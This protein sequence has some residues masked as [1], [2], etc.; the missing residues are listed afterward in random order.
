MREEQRPKLFS[1]RTRKGHR[2]ATVHSAPP[3]RSREPNS[4]T[5]AGS[6]L[7][8]REAF[9]DLHEIRSRLE[10]ANDR[11]VEL[12]ELAPVGFL[13]LD[14]HGC[15]REI[16]KRAAQM[17]AFPV[18]WLI[19]KPF[20]VFVARH[21][22]KRFLSYMISLRKTQPK[23]IQ[24]D[25]FVDE[26]LLPVQLIGQTTRTGHAMIHKMTL[27]DLTDRKGNE[28]RLE[29]L[30]S[31]WHSLI[32]N[33][34]DVV[35]TLGQS[36]KILFVNRPVWGY[37]VR[38]LVGTH[39]IDF[40]PEEERPAFQK[41]LDSVFKTGKRASCDVAGIDGDKNSWF[42]FSFGPMDG[43]RDGEAGGTTLLIREISEHKHVE[44]KLRSSG[45]TMRQFAARAEAVREDERT[46]LAR[47]IHDE[48][49]QALT[50]LKLDLAWVNNKLPPAQRAI[51][52]RM[53]AMIGQV[54]QT[55]QRVRQIASDLRPSILDDLGLVAAI[56]W[57][58]SEFKKRVGMQCKI[59]TSNVDDLELD[60]DRSAALFRVV[61]EALTNVVRHAQA[62]SV[63]VVLQLND[64]VLHLRISDNGR[65]FNESDING[66]GSPGSPGS[67]GLLGSL[68]IIGMRERIARVGGE[69]AIH[70]QLT[71][72]TEVVINLRI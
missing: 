71:K 7:S 37:S 15:I 68:G 8:D 70:S 41:C 13:S 69:F 38:A 26:R 72:G 2:K 4:P 9:R 29:E 23:P 60:S 32:E 59:E 62:T 17:L 56:E 57:Q 39:I 43:G 12:Y 11:Y 36:G 35:M 53:T 24:L 54:D 6:V 67:P 14:Q 16:N 18:S 27:V 5:A 48:L 25:L 22:V 61:Q 40:V 44:E 31:N 52:N 65:G 10:E 1:R 19:D 20:V 28:K 47:E 66:P 45:E 50:I 34:P 33:V 64:G 21:D 51:R 42:N 46:R 55:I 58:L 63:R 49:G 30:L 3:T